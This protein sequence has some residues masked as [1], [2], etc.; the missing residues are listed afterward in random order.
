MKNKSRH[1]MMKGKSSSRGPG[2]LG[3]ISSVADNEC[4][5]IKTNAANRGYYVTSLNDLL[6]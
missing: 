5:G 4:Q 3:F 6:Y 2:N 1:L